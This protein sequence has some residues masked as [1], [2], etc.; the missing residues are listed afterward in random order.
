MKRREFGNDSVG[1][2]IEKE[3]AESTYDLKNVTKG[4]ILHP[5]KRKELEIGL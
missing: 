4:S 3:P 1:Q 2:F 5:I